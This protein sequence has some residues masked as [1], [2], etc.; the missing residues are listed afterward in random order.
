MTHGTIIQSIDGDGHTF[1][2]II[3]EVL[4]FNTPD[5]KLHQNSSSL[6]LTTNACESFH[7]HLSKYLYHPKPDINLFIMKLKEYQN[8][9]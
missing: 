5:D 6:Q 8:M 1:I 2:I 9:I 3:R 4:L 7:S